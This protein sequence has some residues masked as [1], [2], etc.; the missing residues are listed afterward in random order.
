[1]TVQ[2]DSTSEALRPRR[3]VA[4][5]AR[6]RGYA[7]H[8]WQVST[9]KEVSYE[10]V[11]SPG[12]LDPSNSTLA[13]AGGPAG[14]RSGRRLVV[15][16]ATVHRLYGA[17]ISAYFA[18]QAV[19]HEICVV[20]AHESV[21][22]MDTVFEIVASMDAFGISRRREPV[23]AI[24]GGVLTDLVGLAASLYRRSTPYMRVPTTLIGMVDAAIGAKTG[25]NF[26]RHKNR[27]GTYHPSAVTL[28]DREFLRTLTPRHLRNGIAEILKM[29]LVKDAALFEH[30]EAHGPRLVDERMQSAGSS[31][32][33]GVAEEV[34]AR[35]IG[36]MLEELQ[37]NLWE[38]ELQRLV[39]FGHSFSPAIEMTA[40][41][42]LLHGEAVCIDMAFSA[43]L[44]HRRRL[45]DRGDLT[46]I[47][48]VM[49][50]LELPAWHPVCTPELMAGGLADTVKHRDGKQ[51]LP[52]PDGI[53]RVRF[54]NDVSRTEVDAALDMLVDLRGGADV[55][56]MTSGKRGA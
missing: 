26:R 37:P 42:E 3:T 45:L 8:T 16:D 36:G 17:R 34:V 48:R 41:P 52:L 19:E 24:G 15:V 11:L 46:R 50:R 25:V 40:L 27:L 22:S 20:D 38:H 29:A 55:P 14:A 51:L 7:Q 33:A 10:V 6:H 39:D 32:G 13:T 2:S 28:I 5:P 53:G 18:H 1:M 43:V 31:D 47:L 56:A 23:I 49:D 30:L 35:A 12:L 54:V 44:A 21:K 9:S 4:E